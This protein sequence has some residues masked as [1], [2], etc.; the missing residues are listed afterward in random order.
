MKT[1]TLL[2]ILFSTALAATIGDQ[3]FPCTEPNFGGCCTEID[4]FG[5]GH[6]C[7]EAAVVA[8]GKGYICSEKTDHNLCCHRAPWVVHAAHPLVCS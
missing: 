3:S 8:D 5:G 1:F 7:L 6:G 2:A 4:E